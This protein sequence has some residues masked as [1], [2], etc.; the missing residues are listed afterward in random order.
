MV[1]N[2]MT[3][4]RFFHTAAARLFLCLLLICAALAGCDDLPGEMSDTPIKKVDLSKRAEIIIPSPAGAITYAY[5]PQY[6]HTTSY[7]RHRL[8]IE[9]L[10]RETGLELR[11]VFPDT[12]DEHVKMVARGEIDI[13]F[14]N[15]MVYVRLANLGAHA[16]ARVVEASGS[17]SFRGQIITRADS[18][19]RTLQDCVGKH[20]FAVDPN[21][22]GG[23]LFV[24][25][26]FMMHGI[27]P[28]DFASIDFAPGPGG[29]Q[30]KVAMAVYAG[31]YD[32]GSIREG[33]LDVVADKIDISRLRIVDQTRSYPGWVY[34]ARRGLNPEVVQKIADAMFALDKAKAQDALILEAAEIEDIIPAEDADYQPVRELMARLGMLGQ[35][36]TD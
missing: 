26:H 14:S 24:L 6:S 1:G 31:T 10:S 34:A 36:A 21:S 35:N 23:Y 7:S 16:F 12:F 5:L 29:K 18:G 9:Y 13:S 33:T 19:I 20:W 15:P 2:L 27:E 32:F 8:L 11:Q 25:G 22:A 28:R 3:K 30:E 4:T 17:P